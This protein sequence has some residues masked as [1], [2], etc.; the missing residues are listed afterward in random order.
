MRNICVLIVVV[1]A[2]L[3]GVIY[4]WTDTKSQENEQGGSLVYLEEWK[5]WE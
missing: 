3:V 1:V 5:V 2:V 4:Y